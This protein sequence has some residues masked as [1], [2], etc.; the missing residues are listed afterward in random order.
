MANVVAVDTPAALACSSY[1]NSDLKAQRVRSAW[2]FLAPTLLIL[3]LVAAWPLGRTIYFSFTN[4]S[5]NNLAE[6]QFIGAEN[7][8]SWV[9]LKSGRTVYG[10]LLADPA[11]W[12]A[13]WNT[14]KFTLISVSSSTI[15]GM[16]VA[17]VLNS[18]FLGRGLVRAAVLVP[19]ALP[20]VVS[21]KMWAWMFNDQFGLI[22]DFLLHLGLTSHKIAWLANPDTIMPVI[23]VIDV[24]RTT[25]FMALLV[26][27]ALQTVPHD[28]YESA[29]IDG[30]HPIKVFWRLTIPLIRP[31]LT[32]AVIFRTLDALRIFDLVYVLTPSNAETV[33][34]SVLTR[35]YLFDFDKF[36]YGC[37][38]STVL[39]IILAG[40]T[41][42]Y[43]WLGR[44]NLEGGER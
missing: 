15:L 17:L 38:A 7:Y 44:V 29:K 13:V 43:M 14:L 19:W 22:N 12:N 41:V 8:F 23:L 11:W 35:Q 31:A 3:A 33:T 32:V 39:F 6:A 1:I 37:A 25:P 26:L 36:A 5:L 27:A 10:G 34:M 20:G 28:I 30:V 16:G 42:L 2:I 40:I 21:A 24:W 18:Q 9:T 4:A